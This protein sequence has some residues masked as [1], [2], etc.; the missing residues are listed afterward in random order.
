MRLRRRRQQRAAWLCVLDRKFDDG[1]YGRLDG[2]KGIRAL[3][4]AIAGDLRAVCSH[5]SRRGIIGD[6]PVFPA[7][8]LPT[9]WHGCRMRVD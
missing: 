7:V 6:K 3:T 9:L 8:G 4:T 1:G 5:R 2:R